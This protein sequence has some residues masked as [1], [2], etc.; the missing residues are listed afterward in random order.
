MTSQDLKPIVSGM[1]V[2]YKDPY[3]NETENGII[4][5]FLPPKSGRTEDIEEVFVVYKSTCGGVWEKYHNFTAQRTKLSSLHLGWT[6]RL[7]WDMEK[8]KKQAEN[9]L[10]YSY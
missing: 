5:T 1:K 9:N 7:N 10:K 6:T 8:L 2:H 3:T 4:Q